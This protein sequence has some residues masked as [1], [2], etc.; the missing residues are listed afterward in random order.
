MR[1][2]GTEET[3]S[4]PW[5]RSSCLRLTVLLSSAPGLSLEHPHPVL[6]GNRVWAGEAD[7]AQLCV[8]FFPAVVGSS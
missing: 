4:G 3:L 2:D 5:M 1:A 8:C 6:D 7:K